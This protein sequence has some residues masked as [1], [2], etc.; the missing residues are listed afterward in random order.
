MVEFLAALVGNR[1]GG[2]SYVLIAAMYLIS[3]ISGSKAADQA[4]VAPVLLPEMRRRGMV[5]GE[6]AA[7]LAASAAMSETIPPSLVLIIVGA[8]TGVSISALFTGGLLP[9]GIAAIGLALLVFFRSR[10]DR[11]EGARVRPAPWRGCSWSPSRR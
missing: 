8:V 1:R 4:A 5:P 3:G 10:R 9:A 11:P 6:L 2:L 7:Q